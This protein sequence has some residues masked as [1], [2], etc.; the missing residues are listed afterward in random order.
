MI[1]ANAVI[2]IQRRVC[3]DTVIYFSI[4]IFSACSIVLSDGYEDDIDELDYVIYTGHGGQKTPGGKQIKDQEFKAGN[5]ALKISF[6]NNL[7]I[8]GQLNVG[9]KW[10][11]NAGP[12]VACQ[13]SIRASRFQLPKARHLPAWALNLSM[14]SAFRHFSLARIC[15]WSLARSKLLDCHR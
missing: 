3:G 8:I 12:A 5:L 15:R 11:A 2:A 4:N 6:E 10:V 1:V 7:P 13:E 14:I 9:G